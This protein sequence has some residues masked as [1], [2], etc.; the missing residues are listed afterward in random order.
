M[1]SGKV[2][3]SYKAFTMKCQ[4]VEKRIVLYYEETKRKRIL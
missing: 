1:K 4:N 2:E 3:E